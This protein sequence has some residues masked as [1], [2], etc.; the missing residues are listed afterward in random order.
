VRDKRE[1]TARSIV[2]RMR[3]LALEC[4]Q[5]SSRSAQTYE[6]L[7]EDYELK[8]LESQLQ[9]EKQQ[10][11]IVHA[12]LNPLLEVERMKRYQE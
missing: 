1:Y 4:K 9:E 7:T 2:E 10:E 3:A 5:L 8:A 12:Q 6:W 11:T